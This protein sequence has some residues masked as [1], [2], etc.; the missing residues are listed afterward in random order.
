MTPR[1]RRAPERLPVRREEGI[2]SRAASAL[3][4][5]AAARPGA[6]G[7]ILVFA[8]VLGTVS[9]NALWYQPQ[10]GHPHP[11]LRT[12]DSEHPELLLGFNREPEP[13]NVTTYR[14]ERPDVTETGSIGTPASQRMASDLVK[15]V[16]E[17]LMRLGYYAGPADGLAGQMTTAAI[18]TFQR[19]VKL[20]ETGE[21]SPTLLSSLKARKTAPKPEGTIASA[22]LPVAPEAPAA[23]VPPAAPAAPVAHSVVPPPR[24]TVMAR[25]AAPQPQKPAEDIDPVA[26]AI[27]SAS[28][29]AP[30]AAKPETASKVAADATLVAR[31]QRGLS[32]VYADITVDGVAGEGTRQS[33]RN[34][35][36]HYNLPQTGEPNERVLKKLKE[37]GAL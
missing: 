3:F 32:K 17:E 24:P 16:Q 34:F 23:Q 18:A 8:I 30:A 6:T 11:L 19:A 26:A 35:E 21:A 22:T 7:G 27:R 2:L 29:P 5:L 9:A 10:G 14:I 4:D 1:K 20:D 12:R 28:A 15:A 25:P 37:I 31:I 33:I 13:E 36:K